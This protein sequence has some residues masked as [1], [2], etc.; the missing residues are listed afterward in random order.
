LSNI[1]PDVFAINEV[2]GSDVYQEMVTQF[3][4]YTFEITEGPQTQEILIGIRNTFTCF[5]TQK[6]EFKSRVKYMR[7]GQ[8][9]T[10]RM[11]GIDY[12]LVFLHLASFQEPRGFGLR[13]DMLYRA[14]KFRHKLDQ[15]AGGR[16]K[17]YY[18]FL[19]DL[20][21]MGL[22]YPFES[23]ISFDKEIKKMG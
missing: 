21:T 13:D 10:L 12:C 3:P 20:N 5:I 15:P 22:N 8:L 1:D 4:G 14:V 17:A 7:L 9:A 6:I 2:S 11:D 16:H 18:I 19:G 23:D